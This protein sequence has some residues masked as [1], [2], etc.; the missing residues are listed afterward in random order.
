VRRR[1]APLRPLVLALLFGKEERNVVRHVRILHVHLLD[2]RSHHGERDQLHRQVGVP[3]GTSPVRHRDLARGGETES[4]ERRRETLGPALVPE[5]D[6][7]M[8]TPCVP[9]D[10]LRC[11]DQRLNRSAV[12]CPVGKREVGEVALP[13]VL[14][15][16]GDAELESLKSR[17]ASFEPPPFELESTRQIVHA[18]G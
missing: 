17:T 18:P 1:I 2:E 10:S 3:V 9:E 4:V 5:N 7:S 6:Q 12:Q 8:L 13:V 14:V 16:V 15:Q 11:F